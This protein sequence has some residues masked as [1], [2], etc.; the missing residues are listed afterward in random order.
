M[1][2]IKEQSVTD[3]TAKIVITF[4]DVD[5]IFEE[6]SGNVTLNIKLSPQHVKA[7]LSKYSKKL[8]KM[9]VEFIEKKQINTRTLNNLHLRQECYY[10]DGLTWDKYNLT[11]MFSYVVVF[12]NN[13]MK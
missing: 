3:T 10:A 13:K 11:L 12:L 4:R 8:H 5:Y 1:I 2:Y 6:E 7:D 9:F